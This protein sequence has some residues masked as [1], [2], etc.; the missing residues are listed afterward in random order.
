MN[1][2]QL[3]QHPLRTAGLAIAVGLA[4]LTLASCGNDTDN[5]NAQ[6]TEAVSGPG[7]KQTYLDDGSRM[8]DYVDDNGDYSTVF[9]YCDGHDLVD[10]TA[11][12]YKSGNAIARSVD[13]PACADGK[14]T[15]GD[16][17][18]AG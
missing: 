8:T 16:F 17:K 14:L 3:R 12:N 9:S 10:Q 6:E 15:A 18:I 1:F 11:Y 13:H 5:H 7:V 4:T 2:E